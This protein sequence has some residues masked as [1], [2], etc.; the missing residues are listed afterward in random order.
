[1]SDKEKEILEAMNVNADICACCQTIWNHNNL[2][3]DINDIVI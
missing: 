2:N 3:S 1:M